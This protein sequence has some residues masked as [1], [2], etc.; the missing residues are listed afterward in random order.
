MPD[1]FVLTQNYSIDLVLP[2]LMFEEMNATGTDPL[3]KA[4]P[5]AY[6]GTADHVIWEQHDNGYGLLSL[7]GLGGEPDVVGVPG[8]RRYAVAPGYYGERAILDEVESTKGRDPGSSNLPVKPA[9]R[10]ALITQYQAEKSVNRIR[11]TIADLLR[12]GTFTNV[13]SKG[14]VAHTDRI[15][16]YSAITVANNTLPKTGQVLGPGWRADP[17]NAM[18]LNDMQKIKLE[19]EFG[20]SSE[21]GTDSTLVVNPAVVVDLMA[22]QQVQD[23]YKDR[24]GASISSPE[25]LDALMQGFG[26]PKLVPYK[27]GYYPTLADAVAR[28]NFARIIPDKGMIWLGTRPKGQVLGKFQLTRNLGVTPPTGVPSE[29]S[30]AR[31]RAE[32]E[33]AEGIYMQLRWVGKMPFRYEFDCGLNGGPVVHFGSAAAGVS[34]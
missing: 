1:E 3:L 25:Q 8:L 17:A 31:F 32:L 24:F 30:A 18:P 27:K 19:L 7:R 12:T 11:K 5:L 6:D 14:R 23:T 2:E 29:P 26:L 9:E 28:T 20:T 13:D 16:G 21:F 34:Y 15:D 4:L 22:T 10:I 33:W